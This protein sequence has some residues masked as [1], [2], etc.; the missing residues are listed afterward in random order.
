MINSC[1]L[2]KQK[3]HTLGNRNKIPFNDFPVDH[4]PNSNARIDSTKFT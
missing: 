2:R 4:S 1:T 3:G